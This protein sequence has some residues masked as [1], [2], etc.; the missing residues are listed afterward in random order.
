MERNVHYTMVGLVVLLVIVGAIIFTSWIIGGLDR[1][2][3]KYYTVIFTDAISGLDVNSPVEYKGV[4]VGSVTAIKLDEQQPDIVQVNIRV[5]T[6]TPIQS[7]TDVSLGLQNIT[8]LSRIELETPVGEPSPPAMREGFRYP[9]LDGN[10]RQLSKFLDDL[11]RIAENVLQLS[12]KINTVLDEETVGD[13]R[14]SIQNLEKITTDVQKVLSA[15]NLEH[16][17]NILSNTEQASKDLAGMGERFDSTARE[18]E[19][20]AQE[21]TVSIRKNQKALSRFSE[22]GLDHMLELARES[23]NMA[24]EIRDLANKLKEDP[25]VLI[26]KP[27]KDKVK[28][29]P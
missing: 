10:T 11:P 24:K 4:R 12:E 8:G 15:T 16:M 5:T 6:E 20:V 9:V 14:T 21:L 1:N 3:Y 2:H 7:Y 25:S 13:M 26:Y 28:I 22:Q 19:K 17:N 29:A 23:S 27:S 18:V